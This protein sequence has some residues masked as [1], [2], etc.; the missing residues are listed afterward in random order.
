MN[1]LLLSYDT[2]ALEDILDSR[3]MNVV[4]EI[5]DIADK[6]RNLPKDRVYYYGDD[7]MVMIV[8]ELKINSIIMKICLMELYGVGCVV[9]L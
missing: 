2:L 9:N 1:K 6:L 3:F 7:I 8:K 4:D 5:T